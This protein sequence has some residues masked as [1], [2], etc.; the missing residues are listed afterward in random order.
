MP[1]KKKRLPALVVFFAGSLL[2]SGTGS[3]PRAET[4]SPDVPIA[5]ERIVRLMREVNEYQQA[6]PWRETDRNWIRATYYTGVM[7]LYRTTGDPNVLDQALTWAEKHDWEPGSEKLPANRKT[8]GQTYLELYS[9]DPNPSRIAKIKSYVDARMAV[10]SAGES[11]SVG[12]HYCDTLYVGPPTIA[13]L[14]E[15]TGQQKYFDYLNKV[16]WTVVGDLFDENYGLFYRDKR[17]VDAK[18]PGGRKVFWS[19]G[20]GWVIAGIPRVLEHL[21]EDNDHRDRYVKLLRT[22]ADALAARQSDDGLWRSNLDDPLQHPNPETSGTAFFCYAMTWGINHRLLDREKFLP[23]V[24]KA[25][26]GLVRHVDAEGKLGFVQ[27]VGA[28]PRPA[29]AD[30]THE[31]AV[32]AFLLAGS[33]MHRLMTDSEQ[34]APAIGLPKNVT[35][36]ARNGGWCWYQDPRAIV[37]DNKLVV[38]SVTGAGD[39]AGDVRES[40]Y[41]LKSKKHLGTVVLHE[42]LESDDHDVPALYVRPDGSILAVYARH[43]R[44]DNSRHRLR[45]SKP[46]DPTKWGPVEEFDHGPDR[47][48]TYMNLYYDPTDKLLYNF[49]RDG[50]CW[51]PFYVTSDDHGDNWVPGGKLIDHNLEGRHRPYTRFCSDGSTIHISF[52]EAHPQEYAPGTSIFYAGFRGGRFYRADGSLIKDLERD[53]PL[54]PSEADRVFTGG[55]ENAAWTS[56]IAADAEGRIF[57]GYSLRKTKQDHRFR[58]AAWDGHGWHDH[59]VAYAGP[60][61]YPVAY[62]Y[63]G[64][65]AIDPSE[66]QRIY[67][68]TNVDP[69]TGQTIG[70]GMHEIYAAT[71]ADYGATWTTTPITQNSPM[72]NIRPIVVADKNHHALLWL[73]GR[74]TTYTDYLTDVVG[75]ISDRE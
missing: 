1:P 29:T 8:C 57:I 9:L 40:V 67:Y 60:G 71:T 70:T 4:I 12:W 5:P 3:R 11:P 27:P 56:S 63:T 62:D 66:P 47:W 31:Y 75:I 20:N 46:F 59:E 68:S 49:Y 54:L 50:G 73:R 16:Y 7:A 21:P 53:G 37:H 35:T 45:I 6:H 24:V 64:L 52:T 51:C 32:G 72:P 19:R 30:M 74:Y 23:V 28:E 38:G 41:D 69:A 65:I 44:N 2:I 25:W 10:V 34:D 15:A 33:E 55:P 42:K 36:L 39:R 26:C 17:Y 48:V 22:M 43:G 61:F 13:M 14:G 18:S 58:Y